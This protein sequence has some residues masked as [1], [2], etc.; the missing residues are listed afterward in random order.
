MPGQWPQ[1]RASY[2][3]LQR[4]HKNT[5]KQQQLLHSQHKELTTKTSCHYVLRLSAK[6]YP[7]RLFPRVHMSNLV[8]DRSFWLC[9][10]Q[11]RRQRRRQRTDGVVS[12]TAGHQLE[13]S[14][15][16]RPSECA[17]SSPSLTAEL[18]GAAAPPAQWTPQK[19]SAEY[20]DTSLR[21]PGDSCSPEIK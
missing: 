1:L 16:R 15:S 5:L 18:P 4:H 9:W 2:D 8:E 21:T 11:L 7:F 20:F 13:A 19:Y 10:R 3:V 12:Q 17:S 6:I 14:T